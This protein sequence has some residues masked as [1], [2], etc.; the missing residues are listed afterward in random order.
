MKFNNNFKIANFEISNT[1][2]PLVIAEISANHDG[3]ID[4]AK[5]LIL[6]AKNSGADGVK[7]Q[8]YTPD[9]MT[10]D[11]KSD[12]FSISGG[13]W[14][15]YNLYELYK[16]AHTPFEWHEELFLF[17]KEL[18]LLC[19]SSPFDETAVDLLESLQCPAYKIA[20]FE[21]T[22]LP[23][24]KYVA[25][26]H[27]PM[28]ISTGMANQQEIFECL[29]T[30]SNAGLTDV[31]LLHC[32]SGYPTPFD[33]YN[34]NTI[35]LLAKQFDVSVGL[36]DHTLGTEVSVAAVSLGIKLIEKHFTLSRKDE[37]PDSAF[38]LEPKEF[39]KLSI[40]V[41]NAWKSL[42]VASFNTKNVEEQNTRFRRSIYV[43]HDIEK[44]EI[45][46]NENIK[47]IRPGFG[48]HPK[49][50][51]HAIGKIASKELKRGD[52]LQLDDFE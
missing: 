20:S 30:V 39:K 19:F 2:K 17:A 35:Q 51:S 21:V 43:V 25:E 38:S 16:K 31:I 6:A 52:R 22:D 27:K 46:T 48:L 29:E 32:V 1:S 45:L 18:D 23:L 40:E 50:F 3:S 34:I 42:G 26:Q 49:Y 44:G 11:C 8:T 13:L 28:I 10:I 9:T 41:H 24:I 15:G 36:S 12:D 14:D 37:G 47:R 5:D 33:Q 4:K 7:L